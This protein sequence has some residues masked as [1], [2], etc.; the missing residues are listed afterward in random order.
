MMKAYLN[1]TCFHIV[2]IALA[3]S[4]QRRDRSYGPRCN[5]W[6]KKK[7]KEEDDTEINRGMVRLQDTIKDHCNIYIYIYG[8]C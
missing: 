1:Y 3:G 4:S 8:K 7:K 5:L 2:F 6:E